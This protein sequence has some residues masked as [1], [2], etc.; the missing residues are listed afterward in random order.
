V[1]ELQLMT[2]S[3]LKLQLER[4]EG[5]MGVKGQL[6]LVSVGTQ[7]TWGKIKLKELQEGNIC[8]MLTSARD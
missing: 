1:E 4:G 5:Q 3:E 2:S 7:M 8:S 6:G